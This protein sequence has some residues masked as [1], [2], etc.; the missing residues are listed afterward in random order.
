[1]LSGLG[2]PLLLGMAGCS[3]FYVLIYK[4][5]LNTP[6]MHRFF[7][8]HPILISEVAMFFVGA[9]ALLVKLGDV[10]RQQ[11][12]LRRFSFEAPDQHEDT[13]SAAE[14]MLRQL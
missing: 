5:Q 10:M 3:L 12:G 2:W 1:M 13:S 14:R 9:A 4:G 7:T 6:W 11:Y 8:S